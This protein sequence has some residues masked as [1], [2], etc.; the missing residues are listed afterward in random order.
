[1]KRFLRI[2]LF[3]LLG[4]CFSCEEKGWIA[5]CSE[6]GANEPR[7]RI[8][9]SQATGNELPVKVRVYQGE[10]EDSVLFDSTQLNIGEKYS[11]GVPKQ[12]I[13]SNSNI[14]DWG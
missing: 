11:P 13:Y 14:H 7:T 3:I 1:M 6:C 4:V 5:D 12:E 2:L 8:P 9:F 10:I